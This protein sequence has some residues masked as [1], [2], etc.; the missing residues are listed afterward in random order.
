MAE[1]ASVS[2]TASIGGASVSATVSVPQICSASQQNASGALELVNSAMGKGMSC[3]KSLTSKVGPGTGARDLLTASM[4]SAQK[5]AV[6]QI[7]TRVMSI[8][9]SVH[10]ISHPLFMT[11]L[12]MTWSENKQWIPDFV[13]SNMES[14]LGVSSCASIPSWGECKQELC[15][16]FDFVQNIMGGAIGAVWNG[17]KEMFQ[18]VAGCCGGYNESAIKQAIKNGA[19]SNFPMPPMNVPNMSIGKQMEDVQQKLSVMKEIVRQKAKMVLYK[20]RSMEGPDMSAVPPSQMML[21]MEVL[22][23]VEVIYQNLPIVIDKILELIINQFVQKFAAVASAIIDQVFAIWKDVLE[24]VP[25]LED[26]LNMCW[27]VPNQADT[28]C[29]GALNLAPFVRIFILNDV[30]NGF[31]HLRRPASS[32]WPPWQSNLMS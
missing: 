4:D 8:V 16:F 21:L 25:P 15:E 20:L 5:M 17:G 26:L 9:N 22:I 29:N 24:I 32:K 18:N 1:R 6:A 30:K 14:S 10:P 27:G 7:M 19:C 31:N 3:V 2:I 23:E 11:I 12:Q 28:C 13:A